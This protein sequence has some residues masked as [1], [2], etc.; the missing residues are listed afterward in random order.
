[1][2]VPAQKPSNPPIAEATVSV[3]NH[4]QAVAKIVQIAHIGQ[5]PALGGGIQ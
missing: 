3:K 1:M 4:Q 5:M 2:A